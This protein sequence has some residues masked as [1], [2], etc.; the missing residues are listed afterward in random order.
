MSKIKTAMIVLMLITGFIACNRVSEPVNLSGAELGP[1]AVTPFTSLTITGVKGFVDQHG[2]TNL[3]GLLAAL[4]RSLKNNYTLVEQSLSNNPAS[5]KHPR[6]ILFGADA[7]FLWAFGTDPNDPKREVLDMAQLNSQTGFW[8]FRSLDFSKKPPQLSSNDSQCTQCHGANPRPIW[9]SYPDW[10]GIFGNDGADDFSAA[11]ATAFKDI[12]ARR[13]TS[14]RFKYLGFTDRYLTSPQNIRAGSSFEI[15]LRRYDLTNTVFNLELGTAVGEGI[16]KRLKRSPHYKDLYEGLLLVD[17]NQSSGVHSSQVWR[18]FTSK[19]R[20]L[21]FT[22]VGVEEVFKALGIDPAQDFALG[23]LAQNVDPNTFYGLWNQADSHLYEMVRFLVLDDLVRDYPQLKTILQT[24]PENS[25]FGD[26]L[27]SM[28]ASRQHKL[29]YA[30]KLRG[31]ARQTAR[32]TRDLGHI[33]RVDQ[34]VIDPVTPKLCNYF[35]QK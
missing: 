5:L 32:M 13:T 15:P 24:M 17:C 28:E 8:I 3:A 7:Q 1:Q 25:D 12:L 23:E 16:Y 9:E 34:G 18:E 29:L 21:G 2:I 33:F 35:A 26:G 4:P 30:Y 22:D 11:Q 10:P 14:D 27:G 31:E 6:V 19:L 20:Q